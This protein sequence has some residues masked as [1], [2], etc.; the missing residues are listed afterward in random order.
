MHAVAKKRKLADPS[1]QLRALYMALLRSQNRFDEFK[2]LL[3]LYHPNGVDLSGAETQKA[4][5]LRRR[6]NDRIEEWVGMEIDALEPMQV[7]Q[8][9]AIVVEGRYGQ[10]TMEHSFSGD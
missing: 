8:W 3:A 5:E 10:P 2:Y 4:A 7:L 9:R 6:L 1:I